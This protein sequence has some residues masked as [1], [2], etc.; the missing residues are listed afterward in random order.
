MN[1]FKY[2]SIPGLA[3]LI[4]ISLTSFVSAQ[5][6]EIT[7]GESITIG[8]TFT[9]KSRVLGEDRE[10][11]ISLPEGYENSNLTYPVVYVLDAE[12]L[13]NFQLVTGMLSAWD[14]DGIIPETIVVGLVNSIGPVN[15]NRT[16][17]F[18]PSIS[19]DGQGGGADT[20]LQFVTEELQPFINTNYRVEPFNILIGHSMSG[21]FTIH[22]LLRKTD[23]FGAYIAISPAVWWNDEEVIEH[24]KE[25]IES[26]YAFDNKILF[27]SLAD[28]SGDAHRNLVEVITYTQPEG[29]DFSSI[30]L[31]ED[32]HGTTRIRALYYGIRH[33]YDGWLP[34][35]YI[36]SLDELLLHYENL[37]DKYG[38]QV[39]IPEMEMKIQAQN[40]GQKNNDNGDE[41]IKTYT[42]LRDNYPISAVTLGGL[43]GGLVR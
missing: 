42:Y 35:S 6:I 5:D 17:D 9:L 32:G 14:T 28:E 2:F 4:L 7:Q 41:I 1:N 20:F 19:V 31:P 39:E 16:R 15:V 38:Y 13:G 25:L 37:S 33:I 27:M 43:A 8:Q 36:S 40:I 30:E 29:L 34:P 22:A 23:A 18:S 10:L 3:I 12:E 21:L 11:Y 26:G 24:A